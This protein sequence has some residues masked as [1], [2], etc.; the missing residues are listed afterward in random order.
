MDRFKQIG[1]KILD[2]W[3]KYTVKQRAVVISCVAVVLIALTILAL[4]IRRPQYETLTT[5][6]SYSQMQEI[7]NLLTENTIEYHIADNSMVV[8]V[9][10]KDLTKAKMVLASSDIQSDGYSLE[11][12]L[13]GSFTTT[14]S[15]KQKKWQAY[16][17]SKFEK[18]LESF[19]GV[20]DA[21]VTVTLGESTNIYYSTKQE[22]TI[23]VVLKLTK[24]ID[25]EVA[26]GM[27]QLLATSVGNKTTDNITIISTDGTTLFSKA[28]TDL[29]GGTSSMGLNGQ[30]K[31]KNQ[32]ES[33]ITSH[34][35]QGM[36]ATGLYDEAYVQLKLDMNWDAISVIDTQYSAPEGMEQGLYSESYEEA[37]SGTNGAGGVPGT[38][39]ND[40]DLTTYY[41]SDGTNSTSEYS[42]K[43]YAYLPNVIVTTTNRQPGQVIYD[44]SSMSVTFVKNVIYNEDEV[45]DRGLL[46][47]I[48]W[49]EFKAQN[50]QSVAAQV[51]QEW[52]NAIS[53]G[54]GINTQNITVLAYQKPFFVDSEGNAFLNNWT[55]W[56]QI[57]L[58]LVI[59][60]LLTFVIIRSARPLTVEEK[61]P[62]LSV[63]EMLR[64]TK[65][66]QA[67]LEDIDLQE[68]SEIR[69]AIEKFVDENP[70]AV[71]LLLR[72]WL[73]D[74]WD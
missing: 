18:D 34:L 17:E 20:K 2:I 63:E 16:L 52:I 55:F 10:K 3:N 45:R 57:V 39:S 12:A 49:E 53:M 9:N 31:Y 30:L 33:S 11:D 42:V 61:E 71:A 62:E 22:A 36:L 15:D 65:E 6:S 51:D 40:S 14:E 50:A 66:Q 48:T 47:D 72:N 8:Q 64:T 5:C 24:N 74:G 29:S 59:L 28:D 67:P 41:L 68:K 4:V 27:A 70:E 32:I 60:G 25:D 13:T 38:S 46:N 35:R 23:G 37:S 21:S 43:K 58:A 73:N 19:D 26:A 54:T 56:L 44:S 69:K 7:T 1:Q